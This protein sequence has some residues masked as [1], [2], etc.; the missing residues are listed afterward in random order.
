MNY[1]MKIKDRKVVLSSEYSYRAYKE[2]QKIL[3]DQ[4]IKY[5]KNGKEEYI[6]ILLIAISKRCEFL[7]RQYVRNA[8]P[9]IMSITE[10]VLDE[11][12]NPIKD[13]EYDPANF[14]KEVERIYNI[15]K[16]HKN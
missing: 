6:P 2:A 1:T 9:M 10:D 8:L 7:M 4:V 11:N 15:L 16:E 12:G 3:I 5:T 13:D 14:D